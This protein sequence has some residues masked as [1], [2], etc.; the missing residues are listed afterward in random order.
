MTTRSSSPQGGGSVTAPAAGC[1]RGAAAEARAVAAA[2]SAASSSAVCAAMAARRCSCAASAASTCGEGLS[3]QAETLGWGLGGWAQAPASRACA[4]CPSALREAPWLTPPG[5]PPPL[6][7][8]A[9]SRLRPRAAGGLRSRTAR[10]R[11]GGRR[12]PRTGLAPH[13]PL[14]SAP[15]PARRESRLGRSGG[16]SCGS[17][18][19]SSSDHK[20]CSL[21]RCPQADENVVNQTSL[22]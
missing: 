10:R 3:A 7:A 1:S 22:T 12:C 8:L 6:Q 2:A 15:A 18:V 19:A 16:R 5:L 9:Q 21:S 13:W 14:Q 20:A 4:L 17:R 11:C